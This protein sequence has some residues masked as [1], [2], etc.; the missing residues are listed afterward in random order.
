LHDRSLATDHAFELGDALAQV[1][2]LAIGRIARLGLDFLA[3]TILGGITL[4]QLL[5]LGTGVGHSKLA[6]SV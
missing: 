6:L 5:Q 2:Q 1:M 4:V 3:G